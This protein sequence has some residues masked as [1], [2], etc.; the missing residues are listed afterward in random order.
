MLNKRYAAHVGIAIAATAA[1][2]LAG[3]SAGGGEA[4]E[5]GE[6]TLTLST[7]GNFGYSD[8]LIQKFEDEHPGITVQHDIAPGASEARQNTFTKL[9]AGSGLSDVIGVEIGWTTELREYADKFYPA[10]ESDFGPWVKFQTDPVTTESGELY[11][12]GVATGP[13]AICYRSDLLQAAGLP[14]DPAEVAG[15]FGSWD[16]YFAAGEQYAANGGKG[17]FD[18]AVTAF[19]AQIEQLEYP[20]QDEDGEITATS[21]EIEEIFKTTL[22]VAPQL[23]AHLEPF[24][25]DWAA[26]TANSGFATMA[27]PSWML[28]L[29]E[30]NAPDVEGWRL[31][32]AFPGGGGNWGGSFLAVPKQSQH[33]EEAALLASWLTAPEQQIEAFKVA[34]PFPSREEAFDLPALTEVTNPYF[35]DQAVGEIYVNRSEAIDTVA[36]KGPLFAQIEDLVTNAIV[37]ADTGKQSVDDAWNQFVDEVNGLN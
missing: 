1:V 29:V 28:G 26:A 14:T 2:L 5:D 12:Y 10:T 18:S 30:G 20:Y 21:P 19:R 23:S 31:A 37:R 16:D 4:S 22:G 6:V 11:A 25:D 33:P 7:F 8:E 13:E 32:D 9:A 35:G 3:C 15:L 27:C 17:W 34:G 36:Y 24:T